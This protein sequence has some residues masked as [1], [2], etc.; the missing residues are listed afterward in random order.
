MKRVNLALLLLLLTPAQLWAMASDREQPISVEADSLEVRESD[1]ISIYEGNVRLNQGS[2]KVRSERMV[3]YF[4]DERQLVS[5]EMTGEP[6]HFRQLDDQQREMLGRALRIDYT[7]AGS[8]LIL[9]GDAYYQHDGDTIE[10][11]LIR[12]NTDTSFVQ[13]H[14]NDTDQRV[15]MLIQPKQE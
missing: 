2:L 12:V 9:T 1:N 6:A 5:I 15:K 4:N 11:E 7:E 13:A 14:G 8:L 3:V 10:S